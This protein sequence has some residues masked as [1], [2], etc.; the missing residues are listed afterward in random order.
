MRQVMYKVKEDAKCEPYCSPYFHFD[1]VETR[2]GTE[3][4]MMHIRYPDSKTTILFSHGNATDIGYMRDHLI[5]MAVELKTS[6]S[7]YDYSGYGMSTGKASPSALLNDAEAALGQ[8]KKRFDL[9]DSQVML[10]GQS[11]G[12]GA[13]THLAVTNPDVRALLL[14]SGMLSALRV[15]QEVS[16]THFFDIFAN[17]DLL[18]QVQCPSMIIHGMLDEEIPFHHG[19]GLNDAI[20]KHLR[21]PAWFVEQGGHNNIEAY[22]RSDYMAHVREFVLFVQQNHVRNEHVDVDFDESSS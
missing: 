22:W 12:S 18:A 10:Y 8:V 17:V 19:K 13:S 14:H 4:A 1:M 16:K 2:H 20:P 3:I 9:T 15:V 6:I 21:Y 11:L 5:D 7:C